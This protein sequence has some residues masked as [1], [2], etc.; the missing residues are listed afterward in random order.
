MYVRNIIMMGVFKTISGNWPARVT[1]FGRTY[2]VLYFIN[3]NIKFPH[4]I[5]IVQKL[6]F[7]SFKF[8]GLIILEVTELVN[9][10]INIILK[11]TFTSKFRY[12][13]LSY[14]ICIGIYCK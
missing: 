11:H 5:R 4:Y 9:T 13:D 7:I 14:I 8:A 12:I 3:Y 6:I 10:C 2:Y 1:F